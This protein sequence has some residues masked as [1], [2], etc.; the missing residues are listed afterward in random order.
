MNKSIEDTLDTP[1]E[2][3]RTTSTNHHIPDEERRRL[4]KKIA[5]AALTIP[6]VT[7]LLDGRN[8]VAVVPTP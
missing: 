2:E 5:A 6:T 3:A 7:I 4:L 8:V 1:L